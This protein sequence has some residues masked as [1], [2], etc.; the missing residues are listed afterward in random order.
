[1]TLQKAPLAVAVAAALTLSVQA[2]ADITY[3]GSPIVIN[4]DIGVGVVVEDQTINDTLDIDIQQSTVGDGVIIS[5]STV[6]SAYIENNQGVIYAGTS[7]PLDDE[8]FPSGNVGVLIQDSTVTGV[9][10]DDVAGVK[11]L[12]SNTGGAIEAS[13]DSTWEE[14]APAVAIHRSQVAGSILNENFGEQGGAIEGPEGIYIG[15]STFTGN[16]YNIDDVEFS[17]ATIDEALTVD[18]SSLNPMSVI[19]GEDSGIIIE[20]SKF[21]GNIENSS[22]IEG[23]YGSGIEIEN[24]D[25]AGDIVN[26]GTVKG[27]A[28]ILVSGEEWGQGDAAKSGLGSFTGDITNNGEITSGWMYGGIATVG[29]DINGNITNNGTINSNMQG[30]LVEGG[31]NSEGASVT[32]SLDNEDYVSTYI[33][34]TKLARIQGNITNT[35]EINSYDSGIKVAAVDM[36]GNLVNTGDI[37]SGSTGIAVLGGEKESW[38]YSSTSSGSDEQRSYE[39]KFSSFRGNIVNDGVITVNDSN[40]GFYDALGGIE[41]EGTNVTGDVTNNGTINGGDAGIILSGGYE[42]EFETQVDAAA[43]TRNVSGT[44]VSTLA[45]MQGNITNTGEIVSSG[46]GIELEAIEMKGNINNNGDISANGAGVAIIGGTEATDLRTY[47]LSTGTETSSDYQELSGVASIFEGNINNSG[48]IAA[49]DTG[50]YIENTAFNGTINNTGTINGGVDGIYIDDSVTGS[51]VINQED[52]AITGGTGSAI[53]MNKA[54][55]VNYTGGQINGL[56]ENDGGIFY[57]E[58]NQTIN[59]D[60]EQNANATL[61]LGLHTETSLTANN[62]TL[63]EGSKVLID[64]SKGDLYVQD[65]ETVELLK[66]TDG[67][68]VNAGVTYG[69]TS[70]LVTVAAAKLN[71]AGNLELTF[72]RASFLETAE[73]LS[74]TGEVTG[75]EATNVQQLAQVLQQLDA[76]AADVPEVAALLNSISGDATS[77]TSLLP[78]LT[79]STISSAMSASNMSNGQVSVRARGLASGDTFTKSGIWIQ[80][81]AADAE[82]D[83][84]DGIAGYDADTQGFVLGLDGELNNGSVVGAAYSFTNTES[85]SETSSSDTDYHMLTGYWGQS[86]GNVLVDGQVYYAWG[87]NSSRRAIGATADYDSKLYGA[88]IGTGYQ[89]DLGN[90]AQFIPTLSLDYSRLSVDD[91]TEKGTGALSIQSEDYDR[92]ELGLAGELNKTYQINDMLVTP[93]LTLGVYHDFE[94]EAQSVTAAFAAAPTSTF[95]VAGAEPEDTRYTAGFGVQMLKGENFSADVEYN[96]NWQDDFD[97]HA[98]ALK[99]RWEF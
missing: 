34:E 79:G 53:R 58:G 50:I 30:V 83:E 81:L 17:Q 29:A 56:V 20:D 63:A 46:T 12:L 87:D 28:G 41:V 96:Y 60:Y 84:R 80:A 51:V 69:V 36:D 11:V 35:R 24:S 61:S 37:N 13:M 71:A 94:A 10:A 32:G 65:G 75:Q 66:T 52:G 40:V 33:G 49:D 92:L 15:E 76:I 57:V 62:I 43:D 73:N 72:D 54:T 90:D 9:D 85:D 14:A 1:M 86:Y 74:N 5:N 22:H 19:V 88:R 68:L 21:T 45:N 4:S 44:M 42:Q 78:D 82:Q 64:L 16:I 6:S 7:E 38:T 18:D 27:S 93:R 8:G 48:T 23:T 47:D 70:T 99:L 77:F 26:V 67:D 3:T 2:Q 25:F 55:R 97:A 89:M 98:G 31:Q 95:T 39:T 59:G 91:Y